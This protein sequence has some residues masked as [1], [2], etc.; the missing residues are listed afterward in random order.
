MERWCTIEFVYVHVGAQVRPSGH[1]V[2]EYFGGKSAVYI[3]AGRLEL[4]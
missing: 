3:I 2:D 4:L 1:G